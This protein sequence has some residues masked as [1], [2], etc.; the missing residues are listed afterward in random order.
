M[1]GKN[2]NLGRNTCG[3]P[4]HLERMFDVDSLFQKTGLPN[5]IFKRTLRT[6]IGS[7]TPS[8]LRRSNEPICLLF[9]PEIIGRVGVEKHK[10]TFCGQLFQQIR[11]IHKIC[12]IYLFRLQQISF[13]VEYFQHNLMR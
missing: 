8:A 5:K 10:Q 12:Y 11:L 4:S 6:P 1:G 3:H 7:S 2:R 13:T 9:L